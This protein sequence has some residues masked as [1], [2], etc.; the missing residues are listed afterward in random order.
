[1]AHGFA[2]ERGFRSS[3]HTACVMRT[4]TEWLVNKPWRDDQ[5]FATFLPQFMG[6][7]EDGSQPEFVVALPS[8]I[9]FAKRVRLI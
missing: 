8:A 6:E 9:V 3:A 5:E 7:Y 2:A 1:M 4:L